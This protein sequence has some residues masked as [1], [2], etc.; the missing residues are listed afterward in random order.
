MNR[1]IVFRVKLLS[2]L[3]AYVLRI[4]PDATLAILVGIISSTLEVAGLAVLMPL[5]NLAA[6]IPISKNSPWTHLADFFGGHPTAG[7]YAIAFFALLFTR[8][9]TQVITNVMSN[10]VMREVNAHFSIRALEAFIH[11]LHLSDVQKE[12]IGHFVSVAGEEAM[13]AALSA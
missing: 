10:L 3:V 13:R 4:R 2:E 7:F 1:A 9:V 6:H 12:S 11:H 5:T 8:A